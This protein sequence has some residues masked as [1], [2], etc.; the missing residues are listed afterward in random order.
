MK[1]VLIITEKL[2]TACK[3][4]AN[5]PFL[6]K[7]YVNNTILTDEYLT[8]NE[9][10]VYAAVNKTY[11]LENNNY[12]ISYASGHLVEL[13]HASDYNPLYK[14]WKNIPEGFYPEE[15]RFKVKKEQ[16]KLFK[17]LKSLMNSP[18]VD[19]IICATD[20]DREGENIFALI[21][22]LSGC[23]KKVKRLW[24]D[25]YT[26]EKIEQA[27]KNMKDWDAYQGLRDAGY[28]RMVADWVLGALLT[29]HTTVKLGKGDIIS[30]GRVQTA[31][32]NE[33]VKREKEIKNFKIKKYYVITAKFKTPQNEEYEGEL[34]D[35]KFDDKQKALSFL[36]NLYKYT[37]GIVKEYKEREERE[38][39]PLLYDQTSLQVDGSK[40]LNFSPDRTLALSQSLYEKGFLTY[41]RTAS[42]YLTQS[43]YKDFVTAINNLKSIYPFTDKYS[44]SLQNKRLFDDTKVDSHIAII[45]TTKFPNLSQ[46]T[47]DEKKLYDLVVKRSIA[48]N[49]PPAVYKNQNAITVVDEFK[50][51]SSGKIEISKGWKEVYNFNERFTALPKLKKNTTVT[52]V[53][54]DIKEKRINPPPRYT[55]ASILQFMETCGKK[56]DN[57]E[58]R[59]IMKDKGIGTS[60]TRAEII[61][62]LKEVGY[63]EIKKKV[64]YPTEKGLKFVEI[65]PIDELKNAEFTGEMEYKLKEIEKEKL[66][67]EDFMKFL[68]K[69]YFECLRKLNNV[70]KR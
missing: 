14:N 22:Y 3:L 40:Y 17:H 35:Y 21:Y 34:L 64:I 65:F 13:Y 51:A 42:R 59:E 60:A 26:P 29:A 6:G 30:V 44:V 9:T 55:E 4:A 52:I 23:K 56:I 15:F 10:K 37:T 32:L 63:I 57:E 24:L 28:S 68:K 8:K 53:S 31:V 48:I 54:L 70:Q 46:M 67:K 11:T 27:F 66:K 49:Y 61:K 58:I 18:N 36:N 43:D 38:T 2:S 69:L 45:P 16:G 33:I 1:K 5:A 7:F 47:P 50:F 39:S 41:P 62:R 19:Y 12:I 20:A 25:S